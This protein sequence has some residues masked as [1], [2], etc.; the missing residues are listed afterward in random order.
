MWQYLNRMHYQIQLC[1]FKI[2][3]DQTTADVWIPGRQSCR[4]WWT[5]PRFLPCRTSQPWCHLYSLLPL[6]SPLMFLRTTTNQ[7]GNVESQKKE[8]E[9]GGSGWTVHG[10]ELGR[11]PQ[12]WP[13]WWT[14]RSREGRMWRKRRGAGLSWRWTG[15]PGI[16]LL[17]KPLL[18][19]AMVRQGQ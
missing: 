1:H 6:D 19:A 3:T 17:G 7:P 11:R 8:S 12:T 10:W 2:N 9:S 5:S 15:G 16:W 4:T 14:E 18:S 13:C